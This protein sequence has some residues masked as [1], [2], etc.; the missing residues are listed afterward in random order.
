MPKTCDLVKLLLVICMVEFSYSY[1]LPFSSEDLYG[2]SAV[3]GKFFKTD[4][5]EKNP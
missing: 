4:K 3:S 1:T 5:S 2:N